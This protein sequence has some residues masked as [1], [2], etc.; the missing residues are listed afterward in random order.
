MPN[1]DNGMWKP[2]NVWEVTSYGGELLLNW[3]KK[4]GKHG[5]DASAVYAFTVSED[6]QTKSQLQYV[7]QHKANANFA[8]SYKRWRA[9]YQFLFNGF[10][11]TPSQ[12]YNIVKEY[13][14]SNAELGYV[15]GEL[16]TCEIGFRVLNLWNEKYESVLQRPMPGRNYNLNL[17]FKF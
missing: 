3:N 10:V 1:S 4:F 11:Y 16:K 14:V 8:Y 12:K 5:L 17:T 13:L 9:A 7:P 15:F 6:S 2:S